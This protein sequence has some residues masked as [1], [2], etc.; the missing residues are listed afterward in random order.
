MFSVCCV[1]CGKRMVTT[2]EEHDIREGGWRRPE[3]DDE[4][5]HKVKPP[6]VAMLCPKCGAKEVESRTRGTS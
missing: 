4:W 2:G 3:P 5:R 6:Y 1:A